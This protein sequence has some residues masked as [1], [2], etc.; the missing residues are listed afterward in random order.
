VKPSCE[1]DRFGLPEV[2]G[3]WMRQS[4]DLGARTIELIRPAVPD[5]FL[6]DPAVLEANRRDDYMPYWSY[7]WPASAPMARALQMAPW[8]RGTAVLELGS[9]VGLVGLA[10]LAA[11]HDVTFSDYDETSLSVCRANAAMNGLGA[12]KTLR[13]DWRSPVDQH[14]PVILGCE[15]TYERR[16]HAPLRLL[17]QMLAPGGCCWIGDPG[18]SQAPRFYEAAVGHGY[19]VT[20]RDE[21]LVER[22]FKGEPEFRI[23][24]LRRD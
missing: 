22:E 18:R 14:F 13:L 20:V 24:E 10:A 3:G 12:A 2:P 19:R 21:H 1:F 15:V 11:G 17:D 4:V 16:N 6:E 5:E 9:G 23:F 7:L 8:S